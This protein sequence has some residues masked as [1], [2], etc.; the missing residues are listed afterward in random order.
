VTTAF[1]TI[2]TRSH[3]GQAFALLGSLRRFHADASLFV[4]LVDRLE[5][6]LDLSPLGN[7][8]IIGAESL[9]VP[10]FGEMS[11]RYRISELCFA[12]KPYFANHILKHFPAIQ[13]LVYLDSDTFAFSS[14]DRVF[15]KLDTHSL[16]VTPHG[17]EPVPGGD[18]ALALERIIL[19]AGM[20][21]AGFFAIRRCA[22]SADF[23]NWFAR[24]LRTE[25]HGWAGDQPWLA[26]AP[27]YFKG[28]MIDRNPG[29]NMAAWNARSRFLSAGPSGVEVNGC[30][31]IF[32]HYSGFDFDDPRATS[33]VPDQG[34][35]LEERDDLELALKPIRAAIAA[36]PFTHLRAVR[37]PFGRLEPLPAK[38]SMI[39]KGLKRVLR[40]AGIQVSRVR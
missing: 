32:Y 12:C 14:F 10:W 6:T 20:L 1:Y 5:P 18:A 17:C 23:L 31:L 16:I 26:L 3:L 22:E 33:R 21:N 37:S 40:S 27:A 30:P 35:P 13:K 19:S 24:I 38:T 7:V 9:M 39:T 2:C 4:G 15:E 36:S 28:V 34:I 8:K 25:C 29:L 11:R